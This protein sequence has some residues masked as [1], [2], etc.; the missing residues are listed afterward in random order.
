MGNRYI[1]VAN[2]KMNLSFKESLEFGRIN[3]DNLHEFLSKKTAPQLI[4]CP[5]FTS[6][7]PLST[8]F[9]SSSVQLGAQDC[10]SHPKG[11]HTG[12]VSANNL[13]EIGCQFCIIG[14]SEQRAQHHE[15]DEQISQ[16]FI[17]LIDYGISPIIC[18][19]ETKKEHSQKKTLTVLEK[20]LSALSSLLKD[21]GLIRKGLPLCIAYEPIWAIGTGSIPT[22]D[23]L[24]MVFSWLKTTLKEPFFE[25][26]WKFLYG[27]SVNEKTV[28]TIKNNQNIDGFLVGGASTQFDQLKKLLQALSL[29]RP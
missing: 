18:I 29:E 24:E 22:Q 16:K 5:S 14:H 1:L 4:I 19:G 23:H 20:Q 21:T 15:T 12:Q 26:E 3:T 8:F 7:Y 27:G 13:Q 25:I 28:Y 17:H 11:N 10:S 9:K 2:W 6:L